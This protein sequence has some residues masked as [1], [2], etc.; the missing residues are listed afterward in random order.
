MA[1]TDLVT[2]LSDISTHQ[3][4][5]QYM[6][7]D[8]KGRAKEISNEYRFYNTLKRNQAIRLLLIGIHVCEQF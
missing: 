7:R 4:P 5:Y 1:T 2:R 8:M 3:R 6:V